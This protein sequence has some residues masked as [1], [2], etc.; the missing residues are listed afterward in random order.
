MVAESARKGQ[1]II[2]RRCSQTSAPVSEP[3]NLC[4]VSQN[5][6]QSALLPLNSTLADKG[7]NR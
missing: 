1:R 2:R 6:L 4:I 3:V 7:K 5:L